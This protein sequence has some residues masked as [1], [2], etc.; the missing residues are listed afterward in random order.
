[1]LE[2]E[3]PG[4]RTLRVG[5]DAPIEAEIAFQREEMAAA[6]RA[7]RARVGGVAVALAVGLEVRGQFAAKGPEKVVHLAHVGFVFGCKFA[8]RD[9]R[10][11]A[12]D[13]LAA[14]PGVIEIRS[15]IRPGGTTEISR[16]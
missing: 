7:I 16:W 10:R 1:M 6:A 3:Q 5:A 15:G 11:Q 8:E 9:C 14:R 13:C 12:C 4:A 2:S